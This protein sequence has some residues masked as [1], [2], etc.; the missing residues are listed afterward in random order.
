M[1]LVLS[2][3]HA[4]SSSVVSDELDTGGLMIDEGKLSTLTFLL[5]QKRGF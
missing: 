4:H 5:K 3:I 2:D 1:S